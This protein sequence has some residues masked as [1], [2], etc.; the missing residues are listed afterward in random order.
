MRTRLL[1]VLTAL[2]L[3]PGMVSAEES[4]RGRT[5]A[6]ACYGCHGA[7]A[8]S[9]AA[10]PPII[11]GAPAEYIE[12]ALKAFRDGSRPSTIMQRIAKGYS[13]ADIAAVSEYFAAMGGNQQ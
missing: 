5:I 2:C 6:A 3:L 11:F 7:G 13:D 10:I 4:L 9:G 8:A 1:V 12:K